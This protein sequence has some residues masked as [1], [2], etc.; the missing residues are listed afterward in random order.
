MPNYAP[1]VRQGN[2]LLVGLGGPP[3]RWTPEFREFFRDVANGMK[4]RPLEPFARAKWE[5]TRPGTYAFELAS[6]HSTG[7]PPDREYFF[8]F[9]KPVK[10]KA[11]LKHRGSNSIMLVAGGRG[12]P[13]RKDSNTGEDLEINAEVS[14]DDLRNAGDQYWVLRLANFDPDHKADCTL[15]IEFKE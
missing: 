11:V 7:E 1:M 8:R 3:D 14:E 6:G 10:F 2:H 12:F 5:L 4:A 9:S 15:T 13:G